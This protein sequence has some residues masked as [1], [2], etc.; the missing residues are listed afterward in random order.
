MKELIFLTVISDDTY[1]LWQ[2]ELLL[3]NYN[4]LGYTYDYHVLV[5]KP[6]NRKVWNDRVGQLERKFRN[7]KFFYYEGTQELLD[8]IRKIDYIP[9]MRE[10]CLIEHWNTH[11]ELEKNTIFYHDAD[12]LFT[13][14]LNF[15]SWIQD[16]INYLSYT[17]EYLNHDYFLSKTKNVSPER[18]QDYIEKNPINTLFGLCGISEDIIISNNKNTGGA[19]YILKNIDVNFWKEVYKDTM[20]IKSFLSLINQLYME[21]NN[22]KEREQNGFQSFCA[23]MWAVVWNLWKRGGETKCPSSLNFAWATSPIKDLQ[24]Y[25]I[26]HNAGVSLEKMHMDGKEEWMFYKGR[27]SN[28]SFTPYTDLAY[29][30][31][32]SNRYGSYYYAQKI[33]QNLNTTIFKTN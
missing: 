15:N 14:Y 1:L 32:I 18:L 28:N 17:G 5:Y 23:D 4:D 10:Y 2:L 16:D 19:Q 3:K 7:I 27:Y 33:L 24:K 8:D 30:A 31:T 26:Y 13:K 21:G 6:F 25:S 29:V 12:I 9:L 22:I 20:Q 11:P